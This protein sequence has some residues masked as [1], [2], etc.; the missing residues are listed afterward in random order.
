[1]YEKI[2][3]RQKVNESLYWLSV[4]LKHIY[5]HMRLL[6]FCITILLMY[7]EIMNIWSIDHGAFSYKC[8]SLFRHL[9][10]HQFFVSEGCA[11][12]DLA[13]V[14][15]FSLCTVI[16]YEMNLYHYY[17]IFL[18]FFN[19]IELYF[20][21]DLWTSGERKIHIKERKIKREKAGRIPRTQY[22]Y[23]NILALKS[24]TP[25]YYG[26]IKNKIII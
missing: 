13:L 1:M 7:M 12:S 18:Q 9:N 16:K 11:H 10:F 22:L 2:P 5:S 25:L 23:T 20:L 15:C 3:F 8:N 6:S 4:C 24:V 19:W 14:I 26:L 21:P 17:I